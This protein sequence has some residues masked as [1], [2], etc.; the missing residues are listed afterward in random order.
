MTA[1]TI[2]DGTRIPLPLWFKAAY[3]MATRPSGISALQLQRL[4][5]LTRSQTAWML[6]HKLRQAA[7]VAK[8][9]PLCGTVEVDATDVGGPAA[10]G[11][12]GAVESKTLVAGAVQGLG[13]SPIQVRLQVVPD[14][15][16]PTL[17]KFVRA[18]VAPDTTVIT[19]EWSGYAPLAELGFRHRPTPARRAAS[20][21]ELFR[22]RRRPSRRWD[23]SLVEVYDHLHSYPQMAQLAA[24]PLL[25][26]HQ[27]FS[28]LK[29]WLRGTHHGID[30]PHL[31]A[32]LDEYT[33]RA[34]H[35]WRPM[36]TVQTLL[37]LLVR[38]SPEA[39][40]PPSAT[41]DWEQRQGV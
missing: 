6:L 12:G 40:L 32:Y 2:L 23:P 15:S 35:R 27:V 28:D 1:G 5:G 14:G 7:G 19:D 38:G 37:D 22:H 34:N 41:A 13:W 20:L 24:D 29:T 21:A 25:G 36:A 26:I 31:Q 10:G 30:P 3:L 39:T 9:P 33:F 4:L 17:T 18:V 11:M 16:G 8:R